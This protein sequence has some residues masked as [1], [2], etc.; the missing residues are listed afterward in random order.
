MGTGPS[1]RTLVK[2]LR[3]AQRRT[4]LHHPCAS[5]LRW[6][7]L[8][9]QDQEAGSPQGLGLLLLPTQ[10]GPR[11]ACPSASWGAT[12]GS[13]RGQWVCPLTSTFPLGGTEQW[14]RVLKNGKWLT[15]AFGTRPLRQG[16]ANSWFSLRVSG[17]VA[18]LPIQA[19]LS[20][21]LCESPQPPRVVTRSATI[22]VSFLPRWPRAQE[23][24]SWDRVSPP[25]DCAPVPLDPAPLT[26][27]LFTNLPYF[28]LEPF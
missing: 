13:P 18:P 8:S 7:Q 27:L 5:E 6:A 2:G 1:L 26:A 21:A 3:K 28:S 14:G 16:E 22:K 4:G 9:E 23:L 19:T 11:M 15:L 25:Q 12:Q 20:K 24:L 10:A 17:H